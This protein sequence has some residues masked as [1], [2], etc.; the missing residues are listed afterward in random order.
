MENMSR[1]QQVFK[2]L[3]DNED[4]LYGAD[5]KLLYKEFKDSGLSRN[6]LRS[7][8]SRLKEKINSGDF[9]PEKE[10]PDFPDTEEGEFYSRFCGKSGSLN[11]KLIL[12]IVGFIIVNLI[13]YKLI[14]KIFK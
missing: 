8:K 14:R 5:N 12:K 6:R 7:Y 13:I 11:Y 2:W 10:E 1:Q 3:L 4:V 9:D